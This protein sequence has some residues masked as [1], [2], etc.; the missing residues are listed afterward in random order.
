V[1]YKRKRKGTFQ[2]IEN[3]IVEYGHEG[4]EGMLERNDKKKFISQAMSKLNEAD[5]LAIT[6][7]YLQEFSLEEIADIT[8]MQ[9]NTVKV[10]VHRARQRLADE[11]KLILQKEALTL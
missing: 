10:R 5:H 7:F 11:L 9:A 8:G 4:G 6:L 3:V 2:S 1:S